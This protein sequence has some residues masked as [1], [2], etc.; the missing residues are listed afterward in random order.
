LGRTF[1]KGVRII[2]FGIYCPG[3]FIKLTQLFMVAVSFF[4]TSSLSFS[5]PYNFATCQKLISF[6]AVSF[7][8]ISS[9]SGNKKT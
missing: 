2:S 7:G 6:T 4:L 8:I 5:N 1:R 9:I 3:D